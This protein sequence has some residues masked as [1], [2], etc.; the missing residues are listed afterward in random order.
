MADERR[1]NR[2]DPSRDLAGQPEQPPNPRS[3]PARDRAPAR[4]S[5]KLGAMNR[6]LETLREK[7]AAGVLP[8][9]LPVRATRGKGDGQLCSG[10]DTPIEPA[11]IQ[12]ELDFGAGQ[13]LRL[14][15]DCELGWRRET[16]N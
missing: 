5:G 3:D 1:F 2:M 16:R 15:A 11:H 4:P 8:K 10:C 7:L 6:P 9:S 12:Y 13:I 14:H